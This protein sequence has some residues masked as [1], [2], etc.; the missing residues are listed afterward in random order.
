MFIPGHDRS[1][2]MFIPGPDI[3]YIAMLIPG[4]VMTSG[5]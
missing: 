5:A 2:A 3:R 4:L 1:I